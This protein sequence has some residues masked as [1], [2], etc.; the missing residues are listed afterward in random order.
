MSRNKFVN[1]VA[2]YAAKMFSKPIRETSASF[3]DELFA[4]FTT[5]DTVNDV[6]GGACII[7][8]GNKI[9]LGSGNFSGVGIEK[10]TRVQ[11]ATVRQYT[12]LNQK[13]NETKRPPSMF[14]RKSKAEL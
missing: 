5:G 7:M 12:C 9:R 4:A 2:L 8:S 10:S 3:T 11:I 14:R 1:I 13:G 6:G